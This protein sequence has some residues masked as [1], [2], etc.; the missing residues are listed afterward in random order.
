VSESRPHSIYSGKYRP[1][2]KKRK[3]NWRIVGLVVLLLAVALDLVAATTYFADKRFFVAVA[4]D[5]MN[6]DRL[7]GR[8]RLERFVDFAHKQLERPT[9]EELPPLTR[10]YYR[11]NPFHPSAR[12]VVMR[13]CDY[14]GGCGSSSRVVM[15]LL[16]ASGIKSRSLILLDED[17]NRI[18]AVVNARIGNTW[19]VADPLYGIVF[20]SQSGRLVT[21]EQLKRNPILFNINVLENE[22]YP[23]DVFTYNNY[24]LMNWKK[25]PVILPA[26]KWVLTKAIGEERTARIQ[27]PKLWMYPLPAFAT[28]F[29]VF[30]LVFWVFT[31]LATRKTREDRPVEAKRII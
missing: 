30:A 21:A 15:A 31:R 26:V 6:E 25:I 28:L 16:D 11:F 14:R 22:A 7:T 17:G 1:Q 2:P 10:L 24:A 20:K 3:V 9:Y 29:T 18:H 27:R 4:A 13:G 12:D 5:I 8:E 19:A 23:A